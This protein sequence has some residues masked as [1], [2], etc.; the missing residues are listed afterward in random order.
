[1]IPLLTIYAENGSQL[2][3][4]QAFIYKEYMYMRYSPGNQKYIGKKWDLFADKKTLMKRH[5][6][7][8]LDTYKRVLVKISNMGWWDRD[9]NY[10][11]FNDDQIRA[12]N[13]IAV[14]SGEKDIY[15]E[16]YGE[17]EYRTQENKDDNYKSGKIKNEPLR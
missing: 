3:R 7:T 1:M 14:E 17:D 13:K 10:I 5:G 6:Y 16:D 9:K 11:R 12:A 15:G 4:E 2:S 8:S